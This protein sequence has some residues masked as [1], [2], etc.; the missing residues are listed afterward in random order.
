M[1]AVTHAGSTWNT[2]AGN[3]TVTATPAVNDLIVV[4]ASSSGLSGGTTSVTDDN[5]SGT[6]T[7]VDSDR[8][9]FSTTGTLTVWVRDTLIGSA[10]STVFTAAQSGS[11]GGGLTV[12]RVSGMGVAGSVA[13]RSNGGQSA[14][15][16]GT[17]PAPV[18]S[19]TP[20]SQNPVIGALGT[21]NNSTANATPRSSPQYAEHSDLGYNTPATGIE[22]MS[23]DSGETSATITWGSNVTNA[24]ASVAIELRAP[25]AKQ[26]IGFLIGT[27]SGADATTY[28]ETGVAVSERVGS[29]IRTSE[30]MKA[31][32]AV[33]EAVAEGASAITW[34]DEGAGVTEFVSAGATE[35][36][37]VY[38]KTG[39]AEAL[40]VSA[41]TAE[42]GT[43]FP[44]TGIA[45]APFV[46]S[47][48]KA[49]EY[50]SVGTAILEGSASGTGVRPGEKAG[51]GVLDATADGAM[52]IEISSFGDAVLGATGG[53]EYVLE[54]PRSGAAE[55]SL[56]GGAD[57]DLEAARSGAA[58]LGSESAGAYEREQL[59]DGIGV[60][61]LYAF[62]DRGAVTYERE[63]VGILNG[64]VR[65]RSTHPPLQ[66]RVAGAGTSLGST[67][68]ADTE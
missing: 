6:Y 64:T 50:A 61:A 10:T 59:R 28:A 11:S 35:K 2:T 1:A 16:G 25:F 42:K 62:G 47:G 27:A 58:E 53:G 23:I 32:V 17:A 43:T 19:N 46:A 15:T 56:T 21:G 65:G 63:G 31:N 45:E 52:E 30:S 8:T 26:E 34:A 22:V 5:S 7:Q 39:V 4:V 3:K 51:S 24:W 48:T 40:F 29:G 20:L 36:N 54:S 12:L 60:M 57:G 49:R 13:V 55:T 41:G 38:P 37:T 9:G 33:L 14:G 18:L 68:V 66:D 67:S 44:K